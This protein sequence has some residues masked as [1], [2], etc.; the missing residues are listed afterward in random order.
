MNSK[1]KGDSYEEFV[2]NVYTALLYSENESGVKNIKINK[3]IKIKD[4]LGNDR[5]IDVYWEYQILGQTYRTAVECKNYNST[6]SIDR[7]EAFATKIRTLGLSKGIMATKIG[8]KSGAVSISKDNN[9]SLI[10]IREP[11]DEDWEGRIKKI[12]LHMHYLPPPE[13]LIDTFQP[14]L[15]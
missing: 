11:A 8:F 15:D 5:Q 10:I 9:I 2:R 7:V 6:I 3:N 13:I 14:C 12:V 4:K 1:E